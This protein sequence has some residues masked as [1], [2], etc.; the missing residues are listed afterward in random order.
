M[1]RQ[2]KDCVVFSNIYQQSVYYREI[3]NTYLICYWAKLEK[4]FYT[5][6]PWRVLTQ[7]IVSDVKF[8]PASASMWY[9]CFQW[10][11]LVCCSSSKVPYLFCSAWLR[12][13]NTPREKKRKNLLIQFIIFYNIAYCQLIHKNP[14]KIKQQQQW[15]F[16]TRSLCSMM[17]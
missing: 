3:K 7:L 13:K 6:K 2:R 12:K 1:K 16:H 11:Y 9:L 14:N 8:L 4:T 10:V 15:M 17:L 5:R